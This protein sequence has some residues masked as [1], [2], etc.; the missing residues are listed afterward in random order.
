[1]T[2]LAKAYVQIIPTTKDLGSNLTKSMSGQVDSAGTSAGESFGSKMV[3]AIKGVVAAA[4]IGKIIGESINIGSELQQNLGGTEA[5]WQG[6]ASTIQNT[7]TSAYKNMGMSASDYMA[8]ANKIGA[9]MQGSGIEQSQAVNMTTQAMQRA[10]DVASVMG[11]STEEAMNAITGAAKGNFTMMDNIGVAMNATTLEA[12]AQSKGIEGF[13]YANATNAEKTSL[14]MQMFMEQTSQ[15][16]GNFEQE[17]T[18]T[19][20]GSIGMLKS[21]WTDLLGNLALGK[22]VDLTTLTSSI[23]AVAKNIVPVLSSV[24]VQLPNALIQIVSAIAPQLASQGMTLLINLING[25]A[26]GLPTA[27]PMIM[28]TILQIINAIVMQ[29]PQLFAAGNSFMTGL[30]QGIMGAIDLLIAVGPDII[31]ALIQALTDGIPMLIENGVMLLTS[32]IQDLPRIITGICEKLPE[33]ISGIVN[34]LID[35]IGLIIEAGI[36]L[37]VALMQALPDILR[38]LGPAILDL[39]VGICDGLMALF[40]KM[41]DVGYDLILGLKQGIVDAASAIW[42]AIVDMCNGIIDGVKDFFGINSPSK[43][44]AEYGGFLM[45]GFA[46]GVDDNAS[47]VTDS[48][49]SVANDVTRSMRYDLGSAASLSMSGIE[50]G[51]MSLAQTIAASIGEQKVAVYLDG[52]QISDSVTKYQRIQAR[53][54]T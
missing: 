4:G 46:N 29:L 36:T 8:T 25:F 30:V 19:I 34:G 52:R 7:A 33:M 20:S 50:S 51:D 21:A 39:I 28:Q 2:E 11:I 24:I 15:Y 3:S 35:N 47:L 37:F 18:E 49:D 13:T 48:I 23:S 22:D 38:A 16:A 27:L 43:L 32:I 6:Y 14:A 17:S 10:A 45:Q 42:D 31:L 9:L 41:V 44:F 5:V 12:Y 40:D 53:A 54:M 26:A 1:M